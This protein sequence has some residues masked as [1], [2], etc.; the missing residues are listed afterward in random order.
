MRTIR[1]LVFALLLAPTAAWAQAPTCGTTLNPCKVPVADIA[2]W[3]VRWESPGAPWFQVCSLGTVDTSCVTVP[4]V[5]T[6]G[7][8]PVIAT[9]KVYEGPFPIVPTGTRLLGVRACSD[10]GCGSQGTFTVLVQEAIPGA[11]IN[12]APF[13]PVVRLSAVP[14]ANID[15]LE[16]AMCG[17]LTGDTRNCPGGPSV[18]RSQ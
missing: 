1:V 17:T 2:R 13:L 18:A 14:G 15:Q 7:F 8:T 9:N 6:T 4:T 5:L 11:P 12:V 10:T 16:A 3:K